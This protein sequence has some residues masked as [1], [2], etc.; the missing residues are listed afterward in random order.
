MPSLQEQAQ[1]GEFFSLVQ[2][3][4]K[5]FGY[6]TRAASRASKRKVARKC[7]KKATQKGPAG[8]YHEP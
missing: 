5:A 1:E 8:L 2:T 3:Q 6:S 4:Q 7:T